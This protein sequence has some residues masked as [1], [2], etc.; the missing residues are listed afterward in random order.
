VKLNSWPLKRRG[1]ARRRSYQNRTFKPILEVL[2][3]RE[4][5]SPFW[6]SYAMNAQHTADSTVGAQAL[7][8]I[9]WETP[10]DLN[11]QYSGN[12]LLIHYGSAV[13]TNANTVIIPVKTG[14]SGGFEVEGVNGAADAAIADGRIFG[15]CHGRLRLLAVIDHGH[16]DAVSAVVEH[17]LDVV[18]TIGGHASQGGAAGVGHRSENVRGRFPIHQ[19]ML[20]V[21]GKPSKAGTG[22]KPSGRDVAQR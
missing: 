15:G 8:A 2:E 22:E 7:Q 17:A 3:D 18:V 10:V 19:T 4:V 20:D 1:F 14:A 13:I 9:R 6:S 21:H 16:D 11:P 12:D 5:L